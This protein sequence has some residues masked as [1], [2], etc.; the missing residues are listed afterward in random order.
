MRIKLF[1]LATLLFPFFCARAQKTGQYQFAHLD[2]T[3]GLSG[4]QINCFLKDDNGF[5]W[6]GTN[7]GLNRYDSYHFKIFKHNAKDSTSLGENHI[8]RIIEGPG[9]KLW[10]FTP[11]GISIYDAGSERFSGNVRAELKKYGI[12]NAEVTGLVKD[13]SGNFWFNTKNGLYLYNVSAKK[14]TLYNHQAASAIQLSSNH[15]TSVANAGKHALWLIAEAGVLEKID[16]QHNKL[17]ERYDDIAKINNNKLIDY[18]I[19]SDKNSNLWVFADGAPIG[20]YCYNPIKKTLTHYRQGAGTTELNANLI[21]NIVQADDGKIW[22]GTDHGGINIID[23]LTQKIKYLVSKADDPNSLSGNSIILYKDNAGII[24]AGTYKQGVNYYHSGI[25][26]FPL[27]RHFLTDKN[28]MPDEDVDCFAEEENGNIWIGTNGGGLIYFDRTANKYSVYKHN[29]AIKNSLSNDI[30]LRLLIDHENKLWIGTYFGGLDR[31][32]GKTF[33]HFRH[34]DMVPASISDD[35]VYSIMED[36]AQNLWVGTFAGGLNIF[37]RETQSFTHPDYQFSSQYTSTMIQDNAGNIWIGRDKGIDVINRQTNKIKHYTFN[38]NN[39]NS[40]INNDVNILLQDKRGLMWIGTKDG[41]SILDP[42]NDRFLNTDNRA[43]LPANEISNIVEDNTGAIWA[44]TNDGLLKINLQKSGGSYNYQVSRFNEL[45]GLQGRGFNL[46]ASVKLHTGE[47]IFGGAHGFN[48]FYPQN[49][50]TINHGQN[51]L[52]TDFQLFNKSIK[53]GDTVKGNV[54]LQQSISQTKSITLQ[55][56]EDVFSIEFAYFD[57]FTPDK[58]KYQYMLE[59]FDK[60]WITS[61]NS[62]RK[63]TYTNLDGGSYIF[64]V[65]AQDVNNAQSA[66]AITLKIRVLPPFWQT[67]VAYC[68]YVLLALGFVLYL[69]HR[70]IIKLKKEFDLV[71]QKLEQERKLTS[72]REEAKRLHQLD[73][74]KIKFFTNV[75]HEFRTPLSL[76]LSPID[77]LIKKTEKSDQQHLL[78]IKRNGRRLLNLVNQLMDFRKMEYNELQM[79]L[80]SGDIVRFIREITASFTDIAYQKQI[81]YGFESDLQA[82]SISFDHDKIERIFFNLLSNAFKF[83]PS[84]GSISVKLSIAETEITGAKNLQIS[85]SDT[86]IGIPKESHDKIFERFYQHKMPESLLNQGS[87]IGL[88]I[89]KEFVKM[90]GGSIHIDS[91]PDHGTCFTVLIPA[92]I[93]QE[94]LPAGVF[95]LQAELPALLPKSAEKGELKKPLILLVEDNHD[96][97]FYLK[98]NLKQSFRVIEANNGRDG[99][100]KALA[101]HPK[102]VISDIN[103][104]EMNGLELCKKMKDD[105]RTAQIPVILLTALTRD[106]EQ[107]AGLEAGANDYIVKPFNFEILLSKVQNLLQMQQTLK[108][109]YQKQLEIRA[110]DVVVISEDEK[111]I[112]NTLDCI[113]NNITNPNFSVEELA[114]NLNLSRVSLYKKLLALTG[115]TPVDC[116]RTVRLKRAAQ[117]LEK[118]KL[119]IA[120]IGYEAGF[121]NAAYFAKVFREE[122]GMLPSEYIIKHRKENDNIVL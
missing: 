79:D 66:K 119:S 14:T 1:L 49:I 20:V 28:S 3:N 121:N 107:L 80:Q 116:I 12:G 113:E 109:T 18:Q 91:E 78:M 75:S 41:L 9:H 108:K 43:N 36:A 39:P 67:P 7:S 29:P 52:F 24:W 71:Q 83:T 34:Q 97:R 105:N 42:K 92:G 98:D 10:I 2:I 111:F 23:P 115:K 4:N 53:P 117:L 95:G 63:A 60:G 99:W 50:R 32:D 27:I 106:Q 88:S 57:Y 89:V 61:P 94:I 73:L 13:E 72:E 102:L 76:I 82:Y 96:L 47:L 69:R 5:L 103:M 58:I 54:I 48:I 16:V 112:K 51:L 21:N 90:H 35:R 30:I 31:F 15:I 17:L 84:G 110:S 62:D 6:I 100:Q 44:S 64:K 26:Q 86:G 25:K 22:V 46:N 37:N 55:H 45:D 81:T 87:G 77:D 104:P 65:R 120:N 118:S 11:S 19:I 122:F 101:L 56:N 70:G 93:S 40:L 68:L 8:N 114:K 59:G 33:T 85:V 38:P 74:M